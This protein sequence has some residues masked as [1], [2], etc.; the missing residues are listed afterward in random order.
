M[1]NTDKLEASLI[2]PGEVKIRDGRNVSLRLMEAG[3]NQRILNFAN[4]L[5]PDDLLFL[6]TDITDPRTIDE[7]V[8]SIEAG[9]TITVVAEL[10]SGVVGYASLHT[11]GARWT[12]RVGEVRVQVGVDYRG[13]GLG[14]RLVGEI[15][16][17]GQVRDQEDGRDDDPGP[18]ERAGCIRRAWL[19]G[20]GDAPRLGG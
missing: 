12:R 18:E 11:E 8:R 7:W 4:S 10:D 1:T 9:T 5:P 19:P 14:K 13:A 2:Y 6:R 16:R 17:L 3:D 15:F 20:R